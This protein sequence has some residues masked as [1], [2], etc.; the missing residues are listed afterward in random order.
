MSQIV[1]TD[2]GKYI[3][4]TSDRISFKS[5]REAWNYGSKIRLNYEPVSLPKP[6]DFG[7]AIHTGCEVYYDPQTWDWDKEIVSLAAVAAFRN[8]NRQALLRY[9]DLRGPDELARQDFAERDELG[10]GML[11]NY[12]KWAATND[13][14]TPTHVE[15]EFEVPIP[16]PSSLALPPGFD[17][18]GDGYLFR[19]AYPER[20]DPEWWPVLYQGR[21]DM[22]VQDE[23]GRY[24]IVDHKT[25]AQMRADVI[26]F[27]EMDEQM[28]S[29]GWAIQ[30]MLGIEIAGIIYN[31]LYK[32]VPQPPKQNASMR[33]GRW[34]S[35]NKQQDT[36]YELYLETVSREDTAAYE[37]GLYDEMLEHLKYQGNKYFRRTQTRYSQKE[38]E[39]LGNNICLEAI[40]MLNH[41]LIYPNPS[42]FKCGYCMM[43]A[44]CL[45][46]MEGGDEAT[47]LEQ[48]YV[49]RPRGGGQTDSP[50]EVTPQEEPA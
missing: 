28:K 32:G 10:T 38:Y 35:V 33:Q 3:I 44:A 45:A 36:T 25:C 5:C 4:R 6:L 18:N 20:D 14:F 17:R 37:A 11:T 16:V 27:L 19:H 31:E 21:I 22:I 13:R 30:Q 24:W 41:P 47:V 40:D 42:R 15:I 46:K 8:T 26:A 50:F 43:R 7:S 29:Y 49:Q 34:Y 12:F 39:I 1:S 48:L 2:V 23:F 9:E